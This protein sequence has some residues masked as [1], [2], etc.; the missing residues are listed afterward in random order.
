MAMYYHMIGVHNK[1]CTHGPLPNEHPKLMCNAQRTYLW[2]VLKGLADCTAEV[3]TPVGRVDINAVE[4]LNHIIALYRPKG[5]KWGSV[6][7]F[8]AETL[9]LLHWQR[10]QLAFWGRR[11]NPMLEL[12]G[13]IREH[14]GLTVPFSEADVMAMEKYLDDS[15]E[16]KET[17]S[18]SDYAAAVKSYRARKAGY[19]RGVSATSSGAYI[20]G[21]S[22]AA[23]EALATSTEMFDLTGGDSCEDSRVHVDEQGDEGGLEVE[24]G[25]I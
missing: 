24:E 4:S 13:L 21:G 25:P 11:R 16:R 8:L 20:S 2:T 5:R 15:L 10:L 18:S 3:L 14:L 1:G 19:V 6:S 22:A 7:C 9:G 12:A 17:R 23:V